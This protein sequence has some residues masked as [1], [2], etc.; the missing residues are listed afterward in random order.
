MISPTKPPLI[1]ESLK[2]LRPAPEKTPCKVPRTICFS[3]AS[4]AGATDSGAAT[5]ASGAAT[6][7]AGT[8]RRMKKS[9]HV[10]IFWRGSY[11]LGMPGVIYFVSR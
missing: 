8:P 9:E 6:T 3:D 10:G 4:G 1:Q 11:I 5:T 7:L 2:S